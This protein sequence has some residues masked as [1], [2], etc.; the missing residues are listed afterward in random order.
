MDAGPS[1]WGWLQKDQKLR[2]VTRC[3]RQSRAV[4]VAAA[5]RLPLEMPQQ[6]TVR[7]NTIQ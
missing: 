7:L 2:L 5:L 6:S 4:Q 3:E 1:G